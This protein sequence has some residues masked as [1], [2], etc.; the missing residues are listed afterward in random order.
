MSDYLMYVYDPLSVVQPTVGRPLDKR[1]SE[2][3]GYKRLAIECGLIRP[4]KVSREEVNL[5]IRTQKIVF[6]VW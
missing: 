4:V 3:E 5:L 6:M 2:I 1:A